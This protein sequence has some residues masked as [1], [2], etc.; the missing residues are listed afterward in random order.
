M[1]PDGSVSSSDRPALPAWKAFVVQFSRDA[2]DTASFSGRVEH[3]NSG[4]RAHFNSADELL[5]VLARL[6]AE[7]GHAP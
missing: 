6:L 2:K 1:Q 4:R 7:L 3:L 5:T